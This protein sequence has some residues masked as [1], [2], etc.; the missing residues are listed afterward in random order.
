MAA[1]I[2]KEKCRG[3]EQT[4]VSASTLRPQPD[5]PGRKGEWGWRKCGN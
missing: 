1:K 2:D 5:A 4:S 3:L